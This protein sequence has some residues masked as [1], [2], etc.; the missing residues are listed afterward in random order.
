[1]W[2][3]IH[4]HISYLVFLAYHT[5]DCLIDS[6]QVCDRE[7]CIWRISGALPTSTPTTVSSS[8][9]IQTP[10]PTVTVTLIAGEP[11]E[12]GKRN[13][14]GTFARFCEPIGICINPLDD[15]MFICD[16]GSQTIR[17]INNQ[18]DV[19]TL[20]GQVR[21]GHEDEIGWIADGEDTAIAFRSLCGIT[22][23]TS[24]L[25]SPSG[26]FYIG[27]SDHIRRMTVAP[28]P[29]YLITTLRNIS[30]SPS[31]S[32]SISWLPDGI[33]RII[34][35]YVKLSV[36]VKCIAGT[37]KYD[38][39]AS[40]G[41]DSDTDN[42]DDYDDDNKEA[43]QHKLEAPLSG[44]LALCILP[45][46]RNTVVSTSS[47]STRISAPHQQH[48]NDSRNQNGV[49]GSDKGDM[50]HRLII[51][52]SGRKR[53]ASIQ[54]P[55]TNYLGPPPVG[56]PSF[57][58]GRIGW[59]DENA[60][61]KQD[62]E[63]SEY[64]PISWCDLSSL[65]SVAFDTLR[66]RLWCI[67]D[68]HI[69]LLTHNSYL[70]R[71]IDIGYI[72]DAS[73]C[74]V[75][76]ISGDCIVSG[77]NR[78]I[79]LR[80]DGTSEH[81]AGVEPPSSKSKKSN[82][83]PLKDADNEILVG[84]RLNG[85]TFN[86]VKQCAFDSKGNLYV[87]DPRN[88]VIRRIDG[89]S[90]EVTT[91]AGNQNSNSTCV[92]GIATMASFSSLDA[93]TIDTNDNDTIYVCNKGRICVITQPLSPTM[94]PVTSST[95]THYYVSTLVGL[96]EQSFWRPRCDG[97]GGQATFG[98]LS[99]IVHDRYA[100][101]RSSGLSTFYVL[102]E[103]HLRQL[104]VIH[105][106]ALQPLIAQTFL[107][108]ASSKSTSSN[109]QL[110]FLIERL[111]MDYIPDR[112]VVITVIGPHANTDAYDTSPKLTEGSCLTIDDHRRMMYVAQYQILT[113]A[114]PRPSL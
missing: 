45:L 65:V 52:D 69:W 48:S 109:F 6:V 62:R 51:A 105:Y 81:F 104:T 36:H 79:R 4:D 70:G 19:T 33:I 13:G 76:P 82:A 107:P 46:R 78:L 93:I 26:I 41:N 111:I 7:Q 90:G 50:I 38:D 22:M 101:P 95:S 56:T 77:N 61:K 12:S 29:S 53:L 8:T 49:V 54:L 21:H 40:E 71:G 24:S 16:T 91:I 84:H 37:T 18:G 15:S 64:D 39:G 42:D 85:V 108:A 27:D 99:S 28:L 57:T 31:T 86:G 106:N 43:K 34:V 44:P 80:D 100:H 68:D 14:R 47:S 59:S 112:C 114:L 110:T 89:Q 113:I 17:M 102:E 58:I 63:I 83:I 103:N 35:S 92:D 2:Y 1:L 60:R 30:L 5:K 75:D 32:S 94:S 11:G 87:C 9:I 98:Y 88:Y 74:C 55:L 3:S 72:K 20:A 66:Q 73:D 67:I 97:I 25:A 96:D 10:P 23:D